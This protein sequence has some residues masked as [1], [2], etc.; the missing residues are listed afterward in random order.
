MRPWRAPWHRRPQGGGRAGRVS[1]AWRR[2]C[3]LPARTLLALGQKER[4]AVVF[5]I[6]HRGNP[7]VLV[8]TPSRRARTTGSSLRSAL[9]ALVALGA[10]CAR[11][12]LR[13]ALAAPARVACCAQDLVAAVGRMGGMDGA[14]AGTT[15]RVARGAQALVAAVGRVGTRLRPQRLR[16]GLAALRTWSLRSG[17]WGLGCGRNGCA[18][19]CA[20]DLVAAVGRV[21]TRLRPQPLRVGLRSGLGRCSW[22]RG[23]SAAAAT[24]ARGARCAQDLVAAVGRVGTRLRPQRLRVGLAAP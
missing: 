22:A 5:T 6:S 1:G 10:R 18:W 13:L 20:Q 24:P 15:A 21:G 8:P 7:L 14:A 3:L 4:R 16:V 17:A 12:S 19:G 11:R 23:G 2:P 9:V